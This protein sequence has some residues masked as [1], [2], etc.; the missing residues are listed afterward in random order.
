MLIVTACL[1]TLLALFY[2]EEN[3]RGKHAW[4]Q[5]RREAEARGEQ[6][7]LNAFIPK[8]IPDDQNFAA[9]PF[10][11]SWFVRNNHGWKSDFYQQAEYHVEPPEAKRDT[12]IRHFLD[13]VAWSRAFDVVRAGKMTGSQ[14]FASDK[15]DFKSRA[16]AAP[17]VLE[18]L[19]TNEAVFV[20][21]RAVSQRPFSHYPVDYNMEDPAGILLP[22]LNEV[23]GACRRLEL[24]AGA[25]L[26]NGQS[27]S[28]LEDV[29]LIL[30]LTDS[31]N[32]ESFLISYLVRIACVQ[33]AIQPIWEGLA[34]HAWSDAQLQE[35]QARLQSYNLVADLKW[36]L[37]GERAGGI[38][39]IDFV[40]QRG[41]GTL[42]ELLG[43]G[44]PTPVDKDIAD[45]FGRIV[46]SGWWRL[47]QFNYCRLFG[48]QMMGTFDG[49]NK[50]VSPIR[51]QANAQELEHALAGRNRQ[52]GPWHIGMLLVHHQL[53]SALLLPALGRIP[54][55]AAVAQAATDQ[56]AIACALERYRLA[57]GQF[58]DTLDALVPRFISELPHDVITGELYQYHRT[59]DGQFVLYSAGGSEKDHSSGSG[60]EDFLGKIVKT[61]VEGK[62]GDWVWQYPSQ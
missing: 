62:E 37:D 31:L 46:P 7:D 44:Q 16:K 36:P 21:L 15:L 23:K 58:P 52:T 48:L 26:A 54:L 41:V 61:L 32:E 3:I 34:E 22:H 45:F 6:L 28:A 18:G 5:Y 49:A 19:K 9:T 27:E 59:A 30:R 47:E 39:I 4:E 40:R 55:A 35:L 33:I 50:R 11:Q 12:S 25:E 60:N 20:E 1:I 38:G 56:A 57:N 42:I 24:K 53:T 8:P 29:K 14:N 51:I 17:L 13:L 2:T 43:P 10:I